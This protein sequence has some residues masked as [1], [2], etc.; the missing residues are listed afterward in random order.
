MALPPVA[1]MLSYE[2]VGA[3]VEWLCAAFGFTDGGTFTDGERVTHANLL[4]GGGVVMAGWP[5]PDY[6]NPKHHRQACEDARH[7][8][9][10]TFVVD[11]VYVA[12]EDIQAHYDRARAAGTTI[13][14]DLEENDAVGQWQYRAEDLEGHR[15]MFAQPR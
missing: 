13:L 1:P 6:R 5:G 9:D 3:A 2:D 15:W 12:V 4:T 11:G 14:S 8:L 7:W 10:T